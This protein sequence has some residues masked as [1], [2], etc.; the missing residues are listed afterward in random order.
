MIRPRLCPMPCRVAWFAHISFRDRNSVAGWR[1]CWQRASS[2]VRTLAVSASAQFRGI[3]IGE[4][5]A[6]RVF[7]EDTAEMFPSIVGSASSQLSRHVCPMA[8]LNRGSKHT[9][10]LA[11]SA[12]RICA[13]S[14]STWSAIRSASLAGA[15]SHE[16][17]APCPVV[18]CPFVVFLEATF[19]A[20]FFGCAAWRNNAHLNGVAKVGSP[21]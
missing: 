5:L 2:I 9:A 1:C 13:S 16:A 12:Y 10:N 15:R 4:S 6:G 19:D 21:R 7:H 3:D 20:P 11:R 17:A 18:R 14:A 8:W